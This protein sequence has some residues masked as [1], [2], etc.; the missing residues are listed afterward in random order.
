MSFKTLTEPKSVHETTKYKPVA[1]LL[2]TPCPT[3][4]ARTLESRGHGTARINGWSTAGPCACV[5]M[6]G[7]GLSCCI[8]NCC[9][10]SCTHKN[11]LKYMSIMRGSNTAATRQKLAIA[12][13]VQP[14]KQ[15]PGCCESC[16][17]FPCARC[18]EID[19]V[20]LFYNKNLG[21]DDLQYGSCFK[22]SCTRFYATVDDTWTQLPFPY[23]L[24]NAAVSPRVKTKYPHGVFFTNATPM[25]LTAPQQAEMMRN[26]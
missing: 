18:Q 21:Y 12:L 9:C 13:G 2:D 4:A 14:D 6:N 24:K 25:P 26:M 7:C 19:T 1:C 23:E 5:V 3:E 17:C 22:C 10:R 8:A 15:N 20:F 11:T 16:C